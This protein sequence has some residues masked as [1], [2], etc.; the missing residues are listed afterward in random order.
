ME[1]PLFEISL[2]NQFNITSTLHII[3]LFRRHYFCSIKN[4]FSIECLSYLSRNMLLVNRYGSEM[5]MTGVLNISIFA[6]LRPICCIVNCS[7]F[8]TKKNKAYKQK[9]K[10]MDNTDRILVQCLVQG[11][12]TRMLCFSVRN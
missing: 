7:G 12:W 5:E 1:L 4:H 8:P 10:K 11:P 6:I 9:E 2:W 3:F